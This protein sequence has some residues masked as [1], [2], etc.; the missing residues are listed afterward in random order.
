M[1]TGGDQDLLDFLELLG[2]RAGQRVGSDLVV[3]RRGRLRGG[4]GYDSLHLRRGELDRAESHLRA[5]L[6][7]LIAGADVV[8]M[9]GTDAQQARML[10]VAVDSPSFCILIISH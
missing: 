10:R 1:Q 8:T 2:L 4:L 7:R 5:A 9:N 6:D 3:A